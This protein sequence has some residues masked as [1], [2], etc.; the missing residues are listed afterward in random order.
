MKKNYKILFCLCLPLISY[1]QTLEEMQRWTD[2]NAVYK[3]YRQIIFRYYF[4]KNKDTVFVKFHTNPN[5]E[6]PYE[7]RWK[8]EAKNK[9]FA[10]QNYATIHF[11][12]TSVK[13]GDYM[14]S[15]SLFQYDYLDKNRRPIRQEE[16]GLIEY[17]KTIALY[18][19]RMYQF[20]ITT[21]NPF[22]EIREPY[23][24]N[25]TWETERE[26]TDIT[27]SEKWKKWEGVIK[28]RSVYKIRDEQTI[29]TNIG[30]LKCWVVEA[31]AD[32]IFGKTRLV[33]YFNEIY[34]FVKLNYYNIDDS[35]LV[36][37]INTIRQF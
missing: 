26:I 20:G 14:G 18:P 37:D 15:Q 28:V 5:E 6:I 30:F 24:E 36:I 10:E 1:T 35:Y 27:A 34:G 11:L 33:A 12:A 32:S 9:N 4:I 31:D 21:L 13:E 2:D 23:I 7:N 29:K 17:C 16:T 3:K 22:P 25:E 19:P 8:L